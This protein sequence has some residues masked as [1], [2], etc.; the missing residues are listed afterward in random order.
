MGLIDI[1]ANTAQAASDSAMS[2]IEQRAKTAVDQVAEHKRSDK[3]TPC[4]HIHFDVVEAI[5]ALYAMGCIPFQT[6]KAF[7]RMIIVTTV[8]SNLVGGGITYGAFKLWEKHTASKA[9]AASEH[10]ARA[11]AGQP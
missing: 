4:G 9:P 7:A 11:Y 2:Q 8:A 3:R 6:V 5:Q 1:L 10:P